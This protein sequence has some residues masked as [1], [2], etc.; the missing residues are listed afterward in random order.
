MAFVDL[1][2][3]TASPPELTRLRFGPPPSLP[4][5][6]M[7]VVAQPGD[8]WWDAA[9]AFVYDEYFRRGW[10][11]ESANR[12]VPDHEPWVE[13]S[14][15]HIINDTEAGIV[16]TLRTIIGTFDELPIGAQYPRARDLAPRSVLRVRG[17]RRC[18][19]SPQATGHVLLTSFCT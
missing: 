15:Y 1:P 9:A 13:H 7:H 5:N 18:F 6:L 16:G 8:A 12:R 14:T 4:K 3:E 17:L 11:E 2:S 10:C 19:R